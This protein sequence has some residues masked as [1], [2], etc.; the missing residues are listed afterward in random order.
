[1]RPEMVI[2]LPPMLFG[3]SSIFQ[4]REPVEIQ[5]VRSELA[6]KTVDECVLSGFAWLDEVQLRTRL[7]SPEEHR[8]AGELWWSV[9]TDDGF[10]KRTTEPI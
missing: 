7:L 2:V 5:T 3:R 9:V 8:L 10:G 6:V 4:A 1:M